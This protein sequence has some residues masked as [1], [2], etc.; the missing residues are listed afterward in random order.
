MAHIELQSISKFFFDKKQSV[1]AVDGVSF[2]VEDK[3][4]Q[5]IVGPSGCGKT[6]VLRMI[7]GLEDISAGKI[8]MD[9]ATINDRHP[10]DRDMAM[11]FQNYALYPHMSVFDNMAFGLRVKGIEKNEIHKRV[12]EAAEILQLVSLLDRKPKAL[13]GGQRQRVAVGRA[14]VRKPKV[15]L[16]D[17]PLSNLDAQLRVEMRVEL[18]RLSRSLGWTM[19]YVTH[20]Q[21]EAMTLADTMVVMAQGKVRQTGKPLDIYRRP[22][23]RFVAEFIGTPSMNFLT[24]R[25]NDGR[26]SCE[27]QG[28]GETIPSTAGDGVI[29]GFRPEDV[30]IF[31]S[32]KQGTL[33]ATLKYAEHLGGE[34]HLYFT[35]GDIQAVAKGDIS[36]PWTT[37]QEYFLSVKKFHWFD[38]ISGQRIE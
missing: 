2:T 4:T 23:D 8:L 7:A 36:K 1:A 32:Y 26:W 21:V 25:C 24:L 19:I 18:L 30:E 38:P 31:E 35:I 20:D 3:T 9:G 11:V 37:G 22:R 15:F 10:K 34:S 28:F 13:S 5:V 17:E 12:T 14:I 33:R 29:A 16:L 6:T 27:G